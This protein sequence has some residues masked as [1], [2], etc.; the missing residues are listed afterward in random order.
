M[1]FHRQVADNWQREVPGACWFKADLH[2]HTIDDHPGGRTTMP[3]GLSGNPASPETLA[4]YAR[5]FLQALVKQ[6]VQVAGLTPHSPL[7]G[8]DPNTSAVWRIVEEWNGGSDDDG[9][10]F[11][12]KIYALFPGFE[13]AF[14]EG[15]EGLHLLFL[16][17]PG[18]GRERYLKAFDLAM[19]GVSPWKDGRLRISSRGASEAF[20]ELST[21]RKRECPADD[22]TDES[23]SYLVL[24]PHVDSPKGLL[25]AKKAQV[26]QLFDHGRIAG[27]E[28]GDDKL[29][30]QVIRDRAWLREGMRKFR[31]AFFHA[32][33]ACSLQEFGRRHTWI[34]LAA[35]RLEALRQAFI[36]SD[37]RMRI[38]FE[39]GENGMLQPIG[40]PPDVSSGTRPW[41]RELRIK[42]GASFFG[43]REDGEPRETRFRISPDLTCIIGGSMTGKSMFLDGLRTHTGS[44]LPDPGSVRDQV[45]ARGE[46][47]VAGAPEIEL[48][49]PGSD[50]TAP[51]A[52]R[53]PARFFS[54]NELQRLT[55]DGAAVED[56][57]AR[58]VPSETGEIERR[59]GELQ[60]L[61]QQLSETAKRLEESEDRVAEA[62]QA[63]RRAENAGEEM[64][65]FKAAGLDRLHQAIRDRQGWK[66][67]QAI[68]SSLQSN[69][70]SALAEYASV[71]D[72]PRT[73]EEML[74]STGADPRTLDPG[75]RWER[76]VERVE[77]A[78][79]EADNWISDVRKV[80]DALADRESRIRTE[81]ERALGEQGL[82]AAKLREFQELG[83]QASLLPSYADVLEKERRKRGLL[84]ECFVRARDSRI[85]K[86]NEQR[87]AFER[88]A[89]GIE[90]EFAKRIRVR[91]VDNGDIGPLAKFL[92][93]LR[94]KGITRWWNE[95]P[96][97]EKPSPERLSACL[98]S[99]ILGD[100]G[101]SDAV[102]DTFVEN[103]TRSRKREL[104]ALRCPDSYLLEH[105]LDGGDYRPLDELSGGKR[106]GVLLSLLLETADDRPLV[107]DQPE[108]E[109]DNRFLFDTVL[110]ALKRLRG[111]RQVVV[112]THNANIVVNGDA[113]MV[114]QLDAS[115]Q[116]GWIACTGAI[117]EPEVRDAIVRTVDGGKEAFHLRRRK[118]GF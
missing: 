1:S 49:C 68:A 62:E 25:G 95:L 46:I 44:D 12:E 17:D 87:E 28:L 61:D 102:Q 26:L 38:G 72:M 90:R 15:R 7:A 115:A 67:A 75:E 53:W 54:Q 34:K 93:G 32:S 111:R 84:L 35:P 83:R 86:V 20:E 104:E 43:G 14:K 101:M 63:H 60:L 58:L 105:R 24:A 19:S 76:I 114:I 10:P 33:D 5:R 41:L 51:M 23:W 64:A 100:V 118:Y 117:E 13:P 36:A 91:R 98:E 29:P 89:A 57:L 109:L 110:P 69:L 50:P 8:N 71:Q 78:I 113:D 112:A 107:I 48:D 116:R 18:I 16:F 66:N 85:A 82:G 74:K 9:V 55:Q 27:L 96:P 79:R 47:F 70:R 45:E 56:I 97:E 22:A 2:I 88:V 108:D 99:G 73:D 81:V 31:Q 40:D 94:Q 3:D 21:F 30:E 42:G 59:S 106:V 92:T 77:A 52:V 37:S 80:A 4:R 11:R 6:R 39:R 65:A 103:M